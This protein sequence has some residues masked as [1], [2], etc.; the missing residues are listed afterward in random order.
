MKKL[1]SILLLGVALFTLA[2]QPS[3]L[4][5]DLGHGKQIFTANCN[6][7]HMGGRNV[8]MAP[9]TLKK[10]ALAKYLKGYDEDPVAAITYQV[11]NGKGAMPAFGAKLK[12]N[13][14]DDVV[15]Y[16]LDQAEK[17]WK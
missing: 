4:A 11:T 6:A 10:K 12:P 5:A 9:K 13:D 8:I 15:A 7:C 1:L 17:K 2:L 3:A 14:I 16:V